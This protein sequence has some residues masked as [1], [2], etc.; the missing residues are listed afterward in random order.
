MT[1]PVTITPCACGH[2]GCRYFWLDGFGTFMQGSGFSEKDATLLAALINEDRARVSAVQ[3]VTIEPYAKTTMTVAGLIRLLIALGPGHNET[4]VWTEGCDC[5]GNVVG[6]EVDDD[7]H[8]LI[9]RDN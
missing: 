8:I 7:G 5:T 6:I 9:N 1:R 3:R 4:P 2:P